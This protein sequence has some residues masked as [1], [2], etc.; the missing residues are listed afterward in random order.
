MAFREKSAWIT[1]ITT[2]IVYGGYFALT[3]PRL[4][5]GRFGGFEFVGW[6]SA[7]IA[8]IVFLQVGLNIIAAVTDPQGARQ[9]RDEREQLIALRANRAGFY[10]L[11]VGGFFA[12]VTLFWWND[13]AVIA[14][15][16]FFAIVLAE[17][18]RAG[19]QIVDYHR[20][21]A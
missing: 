4:L 21:V 12:I 1:L 20:C 19:F 15:G 18:V 13:A 3:V 14:N 2:L 5:A 6:L 11:E 16:V 8:V 7:A 9:P 10:T 17:A